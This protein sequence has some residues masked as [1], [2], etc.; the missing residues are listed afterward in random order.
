MTLL[1]SNSSLL[2]TICALLIPTALYLR[3]K[4]RRGAPSSLVPGAPIRT[5]ISILL[6]P[7]TLYVLYNLILA[8]PPN[9]FTELHLPLNAPQSTIQ[10]ALLAAQ[11][12]TSSSIRTGAQLVLPP[13]LE[14]LL[15]RLASSEARTMLVRLRAPYFY[16]AILHHLTQTYM[17]FFIIINLQ[18][19]SMDRPDLF[20]LYCTGRLCSTRAPTRLAFLHL[21][22]DNV[23]YSNVTR[24]CTRG[25]T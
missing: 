22:S 2:L 16:I 1:L 25:Q 4:F 15:A 14:K 18:I 11:D 19:R 17:F 6:L 3:P 7:Y 5:P 8:R 13:A 20:A 24:E 9:L 21:S 10:A 12:N 23:R